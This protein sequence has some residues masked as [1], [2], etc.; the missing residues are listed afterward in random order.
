ME[1]RPIIFF[2]A[3]CILCENSV[4][5]I[6]NY[7]KTPYFYF[8]ALNSE[9]AKEIGIKQE[10][11]NSVI[12]FEN[13]MIYQQSTAALQIAKKLKFPINLFAIFI[14]LPEGFRNLLYNIIAS[15]RYK[16]FGKKETCFIPTKKY[17]NRFL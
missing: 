16:W 8:A 14:F 10:Q 6:L 4:Q 11:L 13:G 1:K 7:E 3:Q 15:N 2:D 12:L 5:F 9:K 17:K